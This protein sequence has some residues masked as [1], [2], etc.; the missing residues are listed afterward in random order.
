MGARFPNMFLVWSILFIL[1]GLILLLW[2]LGAVPEPAALWPII[3]LIAGLGFLYLGLLRGKNESYVLVG[4]ILALGGLFVLLT[5]T[6]LS[7]VELERAWPVFMAIV[8]VSFLVYAVRAEGESRLTI[9]VPAI[10]LIVLA[11]AFLPFSLNLVDT[12][13]ERV[14]TTWWPVLLVLFGVILLIVHLV[15]RRP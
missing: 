14:V 6:A 13:F 2:T 4:M 11:A 5:N 15:K 8:G 10:A 3:P 7:A 9:S 1:F 12:D